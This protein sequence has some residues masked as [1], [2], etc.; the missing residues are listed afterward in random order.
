MKQIDNSEYELFL[1][2]KQCLQRVR[3]EEKYQNG[4]DIFI[5]DG[6]NQKAE[7]LPIR[8]PIID[9]LRTGHGIYIKVLLQ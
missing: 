6:I 3:Q 1:L 7:N 5:V 4:A 8:L 2:F 9:V